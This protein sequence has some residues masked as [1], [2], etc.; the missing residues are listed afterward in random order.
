V[1]DEELAE[2]DALD[3]DDEP[4][5][6]LAVSVVS[7]PGVRERI[8]SS[9]FGT[10][11]VLLVTAV[12]VVAGVWLVRQGQ[13]R[14]R[15]VQ[16]DSG[17][18]VIT[19]PGISNAPPPAVGKPA[20]DFTITTSDG[21]PLTLSDLRGKAVWLTFGASW[22]SNCQAEQPDIEAAYEKYQAAGLVVFSVNVQEDN[23]AVKAYAERLGLTFTMAADPASTI[24][25]TYAVAAIPTH[26]FIDRDGVIRDIRVGSLAP[27]T[28]DDILAPMVSRG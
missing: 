15:A 13:A 18:T 16:A 20:T 11:I 23:P 28:M 4:E 2:F 12:L 25:D 19:L 5:Y 10:L 26:F 3:P 8:R 21:S 7:R 22:C 14:D 6:A 1:N 9:R 27:T 17:A 24:A